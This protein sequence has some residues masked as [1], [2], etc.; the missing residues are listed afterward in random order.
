[1]SNKMASSL[2]PARAGVSFLYY[3]VSRLFSQVFLFR[4]S[5]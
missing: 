2:R 3:T 5:T 4:E 1:M